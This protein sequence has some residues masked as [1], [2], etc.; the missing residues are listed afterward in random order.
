[1]QQEFGKKG[2]VQQMTS[3]NL[4]PDY[5]DLEIEQALRIET[6]SLMWIKESDIVERTAELLNSGEI[7]A[8]FQGRGEYGPRA[9]GSRS[10]LAPANRRGMVSILNKIKNREEFRP[11]AISILEE[12]RK[13]WLVYGFISPYMLLVDRIKPQLKDKVPAAEHVDGS[14]RTQT[15]NANAGIYYQLLKKYSSMSDLPLFINTSFNIKGLPIVNSPEQAIE[16]FLD[17]SIEYLAIGSY[18]VQKIK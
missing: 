13:D 17:S 5:S 1:L 12:L 9:L 10:I 8:W 14:V 18:L 7:I 15:V 16:A 11:F 3:T 4:G 6:N 2:K